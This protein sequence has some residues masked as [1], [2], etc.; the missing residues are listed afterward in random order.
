MS[1]ISVPAG[2]PSISPASRE[3]Y[4]TGNN[5]QFRK[6]LVSNDDRSRRQL[7]LIAEY[8]RTKS[9]DAFLELLDSVHGLI[10]MIIRRYAASKMPTEELS[11]EATVG[12]L[13]ALE[14]YDP[15]RGPFT[16]VVHTY[17]TKTID[18]CVHRLSRSTSGAYG[19][20]ERALQLHGGRLYRQ[21]LDAGLPA[22][23][24]I[25]LVAES[26]GYD[27]RHVADAMAR[28]QHGAWPI[29]PMECWRNDDEHVLRM[30]P[31]DD[32]PEELFAASE[33][34]S[35]IEEMLGELPAEQAVVIRR[36]F[37]GETKSRY[38]DIAKEIGV[39]EKK[40]SE[41]E[42]RAMAALRTAMDER[43]LTMSDLI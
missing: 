2:P 32:N 43:G 17:V 13:Q 1:G 21:C 8:R 10:G 12:F 14:R 6:H 24:A 16:A 18:E 15:E 37:L 38:V 34:S 20:Q 5:Y 26:M 33:T 27:P 36:R 3:T 28:Q 22:S 42:R 30:P 41:L 35:V 40:A 29:D 39:G 23:V 25:D 31:S 19:R 7:E 4:F 9:Q 11:A